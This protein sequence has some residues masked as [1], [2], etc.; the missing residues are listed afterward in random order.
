[1]ASR[2]L[3]LVGLA[4]WAIAF[5]AA[6]GR[7]LF[8]HFRKEELERLISEDIA[9]GEEGESFV[10][11]PLFVCLAFMMTMGLAQAHLGDVLWRP[12]DYH[13]PYDVSIEEVTPLYLIDNVIRAAFFDFAEIYGIPFFA[14]V[15][16]IPTNRP[17]ATV[18][19]VFRTTLSLGLVSF[20]LHG[21]QRIRLE[22]RKR[23]RAKSV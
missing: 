17:A 12:Y 10:L 5:F 9:R 6:C 20:V 22:K 7:F 14:G 2:H 19:F 4:L 16:H 8:L 13:Y 15:A 18:V 21:A 1:M 23:E 3:G 11:L